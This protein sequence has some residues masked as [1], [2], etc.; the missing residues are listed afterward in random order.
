M[1]IPI[2]VTALIFF[3]WTSSVGFAAESPNWPLD[4]ICAHESDRAACYEFESIAKHQ[5]SGL[6]LTLPASPR[7]MCMAEISSFAPPSYRLLNLCIQDKLAEL[8]RTGQKPNTAAD[9]NLQN[10]N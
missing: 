7:D 9:G 10:S 2:A 5:I 6:W 8:W 4:T 3:L 1:R